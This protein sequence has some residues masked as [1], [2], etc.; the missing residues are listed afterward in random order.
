[1]KLSKLILIILISLPILSC[2]DLRSSKNKISK[3]YFS[4]NGFA[5]VYE[6]KLFDDKIVDKKLN[7][8][9]LFVMHN[10]LKKN[11]VIKI[12]N[13]SNSKFVETKV[14]KKANFPKIFNI[15]ITDEI[16]NLLELDLNNPYVEIFET[17]KNATFVAKHSSIFDEEINVAEKAPV[18]EITMNDLTKDD[19]N[20]LK[21]KI[22]YNNFIIV[23]S[24][25]YYLQSAQE[26]RKDLIK[27]IKIDNIFIKKINNKKYRLFVGPFKNFNA[28]K[29]SYISLNNFGF[30]NLN[31]YK[32]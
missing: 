25:F 3:K 15:V 4:S 21:K 12:I 20:K 31:V 27:K 10:I 22:K 24:D 11:T 14:L 16:S 1:M 28:L 17:K 5:L 26:L 7:N 23:I 32:E 18:D 6:E 13:P 8:E 2:A 30:E 19:S 9:G 29:T